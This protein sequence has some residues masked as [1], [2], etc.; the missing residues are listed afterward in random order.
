MPLEVQAEC[1][2]PACAPSCSSS[3]PSPAAASSS[4]P[5]AAAPLAA[6]A[7]VAAPASAAAPAGAY[8]G[9]ALTRDSEHGVG[10]GGTKLL[11]HSLLCNKPEA[12]AVPDCATMKGFLVRVEAHTKTCTY[13]NQPGGRLDC[14][15]CAKWQQMLKLREHY[16][17][18]LIAHAKAARR[19]S[20]GQDQGQDQGQGQDQ[21]QGQ[22][23]GQG[24]D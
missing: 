8:G 19:S 16:R 20:Q 7:P 12:C 2:S 23:Q 10:S 21:D 17:R 18:K 6:P 13:S 9:S 11:I 5:L 4:A 1:V 3:A 24:Q 15:S 14:A 22:I